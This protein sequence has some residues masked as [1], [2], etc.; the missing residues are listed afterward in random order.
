MREEIEERCVS[1]PRVLIQK[2]GKKVSGCLAAPT[3]HDGATQTHVRMARSDKP[4]SNA[5]PTE[6]FHVSGQWRVEI[7]TRCQ[8]EWDFCMEDTEFNPDTPRS[9]RLCRGGRKGFLERGGL[10]PSPLLLRSYH[11]GWNSCNTLCIL[12]LLLLLSMPAAES[13]R[14][15]TG[16]DHRRLLANHG[17]HVAAESRWISI[18]AFLESGEID[19]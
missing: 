5:G 3:K 9:I 4:T 14:R 8:V 17:G 1:W 15:R 7:W 18:T 11:G 13:G 6:E 10:S 16:S 12:L 19:Q 2:R